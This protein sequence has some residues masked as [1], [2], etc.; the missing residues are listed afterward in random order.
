MGLTM[1]IEDGMPKMK[2]L[3]SRIEAILEGQTHPKL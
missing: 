2:P 1:M 3:K